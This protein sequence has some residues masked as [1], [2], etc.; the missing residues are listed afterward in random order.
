MR[1]MERSNAGVRRRPLKA[2]LRWSA[3]GPEEHKK[4]LSKKCRMSS[5]LA[6]GRL[7]AM[8][9]E[10]KRLAARRVATGAELL[11]RPS[12]LVKGRECLLSRMELFVRESNR[13]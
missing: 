8:P 2:Q 5:R 13:L 1:R 4:S 6:T 7:A 9:L 12:V 11:C 3:D 10:T